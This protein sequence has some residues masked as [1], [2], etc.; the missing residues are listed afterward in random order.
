MIIATLC[1]SSFYLYN[2]GSDATRNARI[3]GRILINIADTLRLYASMPSDG[4]LAFLRNLRNYLRFCDDGI[5][6]SI[7]GS[8]EGEKK[9]NE[10]ISRM[11]KASVQRKRKAF[12]DML[13]GKGMTLSSLGITEKCNPE[14]FE[15]IFSG[16]FLAALREAAAF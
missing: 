8:D 12:E 16:E 9:L 13:I 3:Y 1:R 2:C 4:L 5:K 14:Y 10:L 15:D 11:G 7:V 6:E